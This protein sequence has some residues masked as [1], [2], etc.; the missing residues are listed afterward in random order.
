M[1][2]GPDET[3]PIRKTQNKRFVSKVMFLVNDE[4]SR[5]NYRTKKFFD[6]KLGFFPLK[7]KI[8]Q[9]KNRK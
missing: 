1:Y 3:I 9:K 4:N 8:R 2:L 5:R 6:I 7:E